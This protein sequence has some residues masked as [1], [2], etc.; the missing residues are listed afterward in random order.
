VDYLIARDRMIWRLFPGSRKE[1]E[2]QHT[3]IEKRNEN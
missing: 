1:I 2:D 3:I